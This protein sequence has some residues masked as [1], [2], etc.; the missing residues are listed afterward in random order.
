MGID[1]KIYESFALYG[2]DLTQDQEKTLR[3]WVTANS[4][5]FYDWNIEYAEDCIVVGLKE[6][7]RG[8]VQEWIEM[9]FPFLAECAKYEFWLTDSVPY[10]MAWGDSESG[11]IFIDSCEK[12]VLIHGISNLGDI[13]NRQIEWK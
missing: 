11:V 7:V 9:L 10:F 4:E 1:L 2:E 3:E 5:T 8:D 13:S 6:S 12:K